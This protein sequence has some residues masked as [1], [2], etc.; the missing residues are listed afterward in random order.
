[1]Q[2]G[3][4]VQFQAQPTADYG[5][6]QPQQQLEVL[7]LSLTFVRKI[8]IIITS[9]FIPF[10]LQTGMA[11][12]GGMMPQQQNGIIGA[13]NDQPGSEAPVQNPQQK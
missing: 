8:Q 2:H 7:F 1:M 13:T 3:I 11:A 4:N 6:G 9:L 10:H 12:A 5:A